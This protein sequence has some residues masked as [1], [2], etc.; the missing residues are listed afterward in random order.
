MTVIRQI[1]GQKP[2][3]VLGTTFELPPLGYAEADSELSEATARAV[4]AGFLLEADADEIITI[5]AL[6]RPSW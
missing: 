3:F 4:A 5:A 1:T 6:N 2:P